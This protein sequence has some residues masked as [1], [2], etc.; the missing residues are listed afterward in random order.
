LPRPRLRTIEGQGRKTAAKPQFAP[1][2]LALAITGVVVGM[3]LATLAISQV[4]ISNAT[5]QMMQNS[6]QTRA[7]IN[8]A[9]SA[10]MELE[11]VFSLGNNPTRIQDTAAT[12]GILPTS[13]IT[14]IPAQAG[15]SAETIYQMSLAADEARAQELQALQVLAEQT[16]LEKP[17]LI[18]ST[19][20]PSVTS[21]ILQTASSEV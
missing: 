14:T 6:D 4:S 20:E 10:G 7:A 9:R 18:E 17:A 12:M 2:V 13:Q 16:A 3:V 1:W 15:F 11:V 19:L 8:T 21:N 5:V